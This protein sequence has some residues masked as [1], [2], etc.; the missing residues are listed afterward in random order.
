[1]L[2]V[3]HTSDL[4]GV[5]KPLLAVDPALFDVWLDTGD[6]LPT[7]GRTLRTGMTILPEVE[8]KQQSKW[9]G[10]RF[11]PARIAEWLGGKPAIVLGGNHDFISLYGSLQHA[12]VNV[13]LVTP[14]GVTVCGLKWAGF[15]E[16]HQ[17]NAEKEWVGEV[18]RSDAN[19][20][21]RGLI[22]QT[23]ASDPDILVTHSPPGGIL[24]P[25]GEDYGIDELTQA[26][27]YRP[28]AVRMHFFGHDHK[29]GGQTVDLMGIRF[30]N[31][32]NHMRIHTI[33]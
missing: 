32:A 12:K 5:Y 16:V 10:Y 8:R 29:G 4:H 19:M 18:P 9:L 15:C 17:V 28:H 24:C 25:R 27:T 31:G 26:L 7:H 13:H 2:R 14:A 21:F 22:E 20:V 30:V 33:E 6:F 3:L 1:M 11:L 23:L